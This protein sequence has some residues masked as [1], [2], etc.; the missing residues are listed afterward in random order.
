MSE[1][2]YN[3][4]DE[5]TGYCPKQEQEYTVKVSRSLTKPLGFNLPEY[6][7]KITNCP[8]GQENGCEHLVAGAPECP[9]IAK[10]RKEVEELIEFNMLENSFFTG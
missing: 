6:S 7:L 4:H 9:I 10:E 2:E 8:Y 5:S 3:L 1:P